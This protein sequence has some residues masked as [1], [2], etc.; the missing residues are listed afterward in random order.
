MT[1]D[2]STYRLNISEEQLKSSISTTVIL[3]SKFWLFLVLRLLA[4]S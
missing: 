2:T 4:Y 3:T 1:Y